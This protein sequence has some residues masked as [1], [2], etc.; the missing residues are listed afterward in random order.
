MGKKG[1]LIL[2]FSFIMLSSNAQRA[3]MYFV[4]D[5]PISFDNSKFYLG[6]SSHPAP[7]YYLQ[8]YFVEGESPDSFT[9]MFSINLIEA[10]ITAE[11][12]A[13]IKVAE[14]DK[15]KASDKFCNYMIFHK[16]NEYILDFLV[17][18]AKGND[19]PT[20]IERDIHYYKKVTINQKSY[21]QLSFFTQR[22]SGDKMVPFINSIPDN[23]EEKITELTEAKISIREV[24]K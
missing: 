1:L 4:T 9:R 24:R 13:Q 5:N 18:D 16:D 11:E 20:I 19:Y 14:L 3:E 8:E 21:I 17:S 7:H 6:W 10:N 12:A 2:F 23:R 15:R 22:A